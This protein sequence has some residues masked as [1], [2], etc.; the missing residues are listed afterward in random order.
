MGDFLYVTLG[1]RSDDLQKALQE[2]TGR[3]ERNNDTSPRWAGHEV[4]PE[5]LPPAWFGYEGVD[6]L[7][8]FS[9]NKAFLDGLKSE[10]KRWQAIGEW[11]RQGGRLLVSVSWSNSDRVRDL[12]AAWQ[13]ALPP[14]LPQ[15]LPAEYD[16]LLVVESLAGV[17]AKRF[18]AFGEPSVKAV[19]L[20]TSPGVERL[21]RN[22]NDPILVRVP[23]GRGS[24]F[25]FALDLDKG[26]VAGWSGRVA[27]WQAL[28]GA[29]GPKSFLAPRDQQAMGAW[30]V[31]ESESGN[32]LG[33][34]LQRQLDEFEVPVISFGWV[35][36]FIFLYILVV[37]P[38]D[39][40]LLKKVFRRLE[41]TWITFPVTVLVIS[42]VAYFTAYA[43]KG[44]D[45]KINKVDLV[46]IDQ[47]SDLGPDQ[48]P[49]SAFAYGS[50]WWTLFSPR[51]QSYTL[52]I[53]PAVADWVAAGDPDEASVMTTW[54]GRAEAGGLG[55]VGRSRQQSLFRRNYEYEGDASGLKG[56][57][58]AVW[59]TKSFHS[60]WSVP[61][62]RLA[63]E[64]D[65]HYNPEDPD[66]VRGTVR[67]RLPFALE[68]AGVIYLGKV[69]P[70]DGPLQPEA[71]RPVSVSRDP[72]R[73]IEIGRWSPPLAGQDRERPSRKF[74]ASAVVQMLCFHEAIDIDKHFTDHSYRRLDES[75]RLA[76]HDRHLY[77][78]T[79]EAVL[80]GRL[81]R[82]DGSAE[83]VNAATPTP[84][85]LWLG[86]LPGPQ[87]T[88]PTLAGS[89][90]QDT[91]IRVFLSVRAKVPPKQ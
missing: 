17:N 74:E 20:S 32:E 23:Y 70:L 43:V 52:G 29:C 65:L 67:N 19:K 8:L 61:L 81:P 11:V 33:S 82:N 79:R 16:R 89:M 83:Q 46:D 84:T 12:L 15:E 31:R 50:T 80:Y 42:V 63:V 27:L 26:P 75:W 47:R 18:P 30:G 62:T 64:A 71:D 21:A 48:K 40:L 5:L 14:L 38:L 68:S 13:P 73:Q 28:L 6:L 58:I 57:P 36:L 3:A 77:Q 53:Q 44:N 7:V 9:D 35:A 24:V 59:T 37:G 87:K 54:M 56:V 76:D 78:G 39:Y 25:L 69:F 85:R 49:R 86:D 66:Q 90:I 60:A 88:R 45:L 4:K 91:Y 51:I 1:A 22:E 72:S 34:R 55:T 10:K 41:W 2:M